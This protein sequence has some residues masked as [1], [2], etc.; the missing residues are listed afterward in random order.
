MDYAADP[1]LQFCGVSVLCVG[2]GSLSDRLTSRHI[3][4]DVVWRTVC[5]DIR[6]DMNTMLPIVA[7]E[8]GSGKTVAAILAGAG[9]DRKGVVV[10]V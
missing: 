2:Q 4:V 1:K 8:S 5:K 6:D 10:Y 7:G 3:G 9:M